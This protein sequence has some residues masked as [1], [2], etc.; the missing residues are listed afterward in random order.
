VEIIIAILGGLILVYFGVRYFSK[1]VS[2]E[3]F[4]PMISNTEENFQ[5][6]P[7]ISYSLLVADVKSQRLIEVQSPKDY[8]HHYGILN[9]QHIELHWNVLN[10]DFISI[11]GIGYV[12]AVGRKSYFPAQHTKYK[13]SAKNRYHSAELEIVVHVFPVPVMETIF[14]P[15]PDLTHSRIEL[16]REPISVLPKPGVLPF[17]DLQIPLDQE[18]AASKPAAIPFRKNLIKAEQTSTEYRS[19]KTRLFNLMENRVKKNYKLTDIIRTI[20]KH[21]E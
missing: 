2:S 21:Y 4:H 13:I 5:S 15:I 18:L 14:S 7:I 8:P 10:A 16:N 20:R 9:G 17:P 3:V 12:N 6:E 1:P 19:F 11:E